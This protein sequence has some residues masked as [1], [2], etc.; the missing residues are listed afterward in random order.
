[1]S[2]VVRFPI[3]PP[4][5]ERL[6]PFLVR[7]ILVRVLVLPLLHVRGKRI[8]LSRLPILVRPDTAVLAIT[9]QEPLPP[10]ERRRHRRRLQQQ[11]PFRYHHRYQRLARVLDQRL[12]HHDTMMYSDTN[13]ATR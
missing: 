11:H 6:P 13:A 3:V 4:L 5:P 1:P 9:P 12:E 8:R 10:N 7:P 2:F